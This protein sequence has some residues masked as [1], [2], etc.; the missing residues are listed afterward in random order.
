[1]LKGKHFNRKSRRKSSALLISFILL[2]TLVVGTTIAYI[3]DR[4][5]EVVNTFSPT[6]VICE[7]TEEFDG[8]LKKNVNVTNTSDI[9]VYVRVKLIAY[10]VNDNAQIIGG[11]AEIPTFTLGT[12][13]FEKNGFYY[14]SKPVKPK[15]EPAA[16]LIGEGGIRLVEYNDADGGKQVIEVMAEAIQSEPTSIVA[17]KWSVD[18]SDNGTLS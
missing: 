16:D 1:M 17:E 7:I 11:T 15:E 18:V 3:I 12:D 8:E 13:W 4:T 10:R 14:Y 6:S 5:E 2:L 9:S